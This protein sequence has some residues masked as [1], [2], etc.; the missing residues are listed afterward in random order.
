MGNK[1]DKRRALRWPVRVMA[2]FAVVVVADPLYLLSVG[3]ARWLAI[4]GGLNAWVFNAY[5]RPA[6]WIAEHSWVAISLPY[7][8]YLRWWSSL[9]SRES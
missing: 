6:Y 9:G 8:A 7:A 5:S 3:P 4:N 1:K 2:C